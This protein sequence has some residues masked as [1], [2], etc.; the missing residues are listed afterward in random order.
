MTRRGDFTSDQWAT[1]LDAIPQAARAVAAAAGSRRQSED[2]LHEFIDLVEDSAGEEAGDLLLGDLVLDLHGRL[3]SGGAP[4]PA[5]ASTAYTA[6]LETTRRAGAILSV[7]A[8]PVQA[9]AVRDW[10]VH[11]LLRVAAAAREGGVL[12]VG[13]TAISPGEQVVVSELAD[14]FG[15]DPTSGTS[16][17]SEGA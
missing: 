8:E 16:A 12:G 6:A 7:V 4:A 13:G 9:E 17:E 1:L 10:F 14:A 15:A 11:A 3:A 2:E 5:D